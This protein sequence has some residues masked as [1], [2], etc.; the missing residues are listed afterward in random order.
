M[1][2]LRKITPPILK[3]T[4]KKIVACSFWLAQLFRIRAATTEN[5]IVFLLPGQR[6]MTGGYLSIF[7]LAR[8]SSKM[9]GLHGG[10]V[11]LCFNPGEAGLNMRY[12][13]LVC[14]K[15]VI[16]PFEW[17]LGGAIRM[18]RMT[19]M[20]PEG[21]VD[22]ILKSLTPQIRK[23]LMKLDR[24]Q[25]NILN[26]NID[27]MCPKRCIDELKEFATLVTCTTA[28]P[29]YTTLQNRKYW[30][31]PVH[32]LP[33]WTYIDDPVA[34][35][36]RQKDEVMIVSPDVCEAKERILIRIQ[37]EFPLLKM[38][39]IKSMPFT[40]YTELEKRAK[41]SITFGEGLDGYFLGPALRGGVG[42]AVFN[43]RFFTE[44][45]RNLKTVYASFAEM[46]SRIVEDMRMLDTDSLYND[47]SESIARLGRR[48]WGPHITINALKQF[49]QCKY[50]HP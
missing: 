13:P 50:T 4:L 23:R 21:A 3:M 33:A 18:R 17:I 44:E 28:H 27:L 20:I 37:Q 14:D 46:E 41:W 38:V 2:T 6:W 47:A 16:L 32:L 48:T 22:G 11:V 8:F 7:S 15:T 39:E 31:V 43:H 12:N 26:Q 40:Q 25:I 35:P 45:Y 10:Q 9:K 1:T 34:I 49:Y 36:R 29:S 24:L 30:G 19:L 5:F 42:F